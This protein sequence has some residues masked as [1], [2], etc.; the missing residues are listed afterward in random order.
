MA[1]C[2]DRVG[3]RFQPPFTGRENVYINGAILGF[4]RQEIDA[5]FDDIASFDIGDYRQPAKNYSSGM[6]VRLAFAVQAC[7]DLI[8]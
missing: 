8:F 4:S 1:D 2:C 3:S 5:K 7:V 6:F